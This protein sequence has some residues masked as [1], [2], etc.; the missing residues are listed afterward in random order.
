[1]DVV[2]RNR[3]ELWP[4]AAGPVSR[5]AGRLVF[6]LAMIHFATTSG[7]AEET[8]TSCAEVRYEAIVGGTEAPTLVALDEG[9]LR[10]IV[11]LAIPDVSGSV[12]MCSGV[13]IA[14]G[15]VLSARHYF[16]QGDDAGAAID[17]AK[18]ASVALAATPKLRAAIGSVEDAWL[19]QTL[20]V[21]LLEVGW[22]ADVTATPT[23]I[24]LTNQLDG[25][26]V[27][28]PVEL[29][30]Y[31]VS[32]LPGAPSLRF[33]V[34]LVTR[35]DPRHIVVDGRGLRGACVGDS[36]GPLLGR[37]NDGRLHVLGVLDHGDPSCTD[38]DSFTRADRIADW[39]ELST[40]LAST[41]KPTPSCEGLAR[42]GVCERG[43]AMWCEAGSIRSDDCHG[44]N[45]ACGWADVSG[46]FRCISAEK[47]PCDGVAG[48]SECRE[49]ILVSCTEGIL[50][51]RACEECGQ[52]CRAWVTGAGAACL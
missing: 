40:R 18:D 48:Y 8:A 26:W 41:P 38:E 47:D 44:R 46:G 4:G 11:S 27:G 50:R 19:H 3:R 24:P 33:A 35:L 37:G 1:M 5:S 9:Q 32:G 15:I 29:A 6:A 13:V 22:S 45:L 25:S 39:T 34:E 36:G 16:E 52:S 30:G 14:D 23:P 31:G 12:A 49:N 51:S 10:S 17:R 2:R 21:A 20:D 7:C 42:A 43:R 28:N